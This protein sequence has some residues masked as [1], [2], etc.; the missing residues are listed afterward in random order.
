MNLKKIITFFCALTLICFTGCTNNNTPSDSNPSS[1]PTSSAGS[2]TPSEPSGPS[3]LPNPVVEYSSLE[4]VS[5]A[6][7]FDMCEAVNDSYSALT[8]SVIDKSIGQIV[9]NNQNGDTTQK[10]TIRKAAV[11][12]DDIS[13]IYGAVLS[14]EFNVGDIP[15]KVMT[16]NDTTI[17]ALWSISDA[18]SD[19]KYSYSL[20]LEPATIEDSLTIIED[21]VL[22]EAEKYTKIEINEPVPSLNTIPSGDSSK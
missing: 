3:N 1:N 21:F 6:L 17:I 2:Q 18:N 16:Y 8:Y 22:A 12:N 19:A 14:R 4:E 5:D 15:V 10:I 9:Y 7:G 13:G 11:E 20:T